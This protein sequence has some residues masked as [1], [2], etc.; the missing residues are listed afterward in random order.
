MKDLFQRC[1]KNKHKYKTQKE[2]ANLDPQITL[3]TKCTS[4]VA[5]IKSIRKTPF[6]AAF[7][8]VL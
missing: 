7:L 8:T 3:V 1:Y 2:V 6:T 5:C 4:G